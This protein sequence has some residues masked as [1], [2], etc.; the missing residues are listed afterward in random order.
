MVGGRGKLKER[1][2]E[3]KGERGG[4]RKERE[5]EKGGRRGRKSKEKTM[6]FRMLL[7]VH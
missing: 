1:E 3:G 2:R 7:T 4:E 6:G 5:G